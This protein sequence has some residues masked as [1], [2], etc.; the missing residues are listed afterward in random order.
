MASLDFNSYQ[1][2]CATTAKY[3]GQ[4][5]VWGLAY[6][7]LGLGESGEGQGV[8][9]KIIRDI[10]E[11]EPTTLNTDLPMEVIEKMKFELGDQLY[12]IAQTCNELGFTL[13]QVAE[14]NV[15][16]LEDRKARGVLGGS[17]DY[18]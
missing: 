12:Y 11:V 9:K 7:G 1:A 2:Q 17:G 10:E 16:K 18:R 6:V 8:I 14:A 4:G 13:Q 3:R 5:T 15:A